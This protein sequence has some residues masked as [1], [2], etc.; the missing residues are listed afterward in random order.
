[1][2][3]VYFTRALLP[4]MIENSYGKIVNVASVSGVYGNHH[5]VH[6]SASKAAVIAM[7]QALA[8]EVVDKGVIV[9]CVSPGSV[10][11]TREDINIIEHDGFAFKATYS[12]R[13]GS[14]RENANLI[15]FL[16]SDDA[17][18][19]IGQNIQIDGC[20]KMI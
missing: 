18:Y 11:V 1:M 10:S 15:C 5:M 2:G 6:Y 19:I 8:K 14:P 3:V 16:A 7:S 17:S 9:N 12:Q 4:T 20:R 13:S